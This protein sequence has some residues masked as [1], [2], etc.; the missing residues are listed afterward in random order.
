MADARQDPTTPDID[1][2]ALLKRRDQ[3]GLRHLLQTY[4]PKIKWYLRTEFKGSL[5]DTGIHDALNQAAFRAWRSINSFDAQKGT[6]RAWFYKIARNAALKI[7]R[8][9]NAERTHVHVDNWDLPSFMALHAKQDMV[10]TPKHER[11]LNDLWKCIAKLSKLQKGII[12]AD[13]QAA[14]DVADAGELATSFHTSKNSIYASR[15]MARK[16]LREGLMLLGHV[17]G[18]GGTHKPEQPGD[19]QAEVAQ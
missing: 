8:Q 6:L 11:F 12:L 1:T 13:L 19:S 3:S 5:D 7:L 14:G 9:Q 4:G 15:S 16:A 10:P 18:P 2:V 17:P